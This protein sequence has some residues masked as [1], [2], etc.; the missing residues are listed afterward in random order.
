MLLPLFALLIS[1]CM[2][3]CLAAYTQ[4]H[5]LEDVT[6]IKCSLVAAA[7]PPR[8]NLMSLGRPSA[9][10]PRT[11]KTTAAAAAAAALSGVPAVPRVPA[12]AT[13][14]SLYLHGSGIAHSQQTTPLH[15]RQEEPQAREQLMAAEEQLTVSETHNVQQPQQPHQQQHRKGRDGHS[16]VTAVE[17][18]RRDSV[19]T[20][21]SPELTNEASTELTEQ[22]SSRHHQ[23][24]VQK[25]KQEAHSS[26]QTSIDHSTAHGAQQ[27][28]QSMEQQEETKSGSTDASTGNAG[29]SEGSTNNGN[30]SL[31]GSQYVSDS[32]S[33]PTP[34]MAQ[35]QH[36]EGAADF[37]QAAP[38]EALKDPVEAEH[39]APQVLEQQSLPAPDD[40]R[41]ATLIPN[42]PPSASPNGPALVITSGPPPV[43]PSA[44]PSVSPTDPP[45]QPTSS[46]SSSSSGNPAAINPSPPPFVSPCGPLPSPHL[47]HH[48][49]HLPSWVPLPD[50][51]EGQ[52]EDL[53]RQGRDG[54]RPATTV[55]YV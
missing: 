37:L 6:C 33:E 20:S 14:G 5:F 24:H 42:G 45:P 52:V 36:P 53:V 43:G 30:A 19:N 54:G 39:A 51:E 29:A 34:P 7:L 38:L 50:L 1:C 22:P 41:D 27:A 4:P 46:N 26:E 3:T 35:L 18:D 44:P 2:Q 9:G 10:P 17:R 25:Q 11:T 40:S 21:G 8:P 32:E 47:L 12:I 28:G 16:L 23:G 49:A 13:D 48:L 31:Q 15:R 55:S